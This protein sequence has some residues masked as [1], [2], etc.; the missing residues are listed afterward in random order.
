MAI[1][2]PTETRLSPHFLLSDFMGCNSVYSKGY[3][4]VF[5]KVGLDLRLDNAKALCDNVLEPILANAGP[6]TISYGFISPELSSKIVHYQDPHKP[7]HHRWDLGAAADI[8]VHNWV[9][10]F[11]QLAKLSHASPIE[12]A[13]T[14]MSD[15][16]LSRLITYS[17]SPYIC[18]AVSAV[19]IHRGEPRMAWYENRYAG[20]PR[21]K[22]D[23]R[24][25]GSD[26]LREEALHDIMQDGFEHDWRGAGYPTYHGGGTKQFQH[27][28]TGKYTM[29]S[30]WLFDEEFV[31]EGVPNEPML[32][33]ALVREAFD[34]AGHAYDLLIDNLGVP[35]LSIVSAYTSPLSLR[36]I[37]G[38]DWTGDQIVFEVVPPE[39]RPP[40]D[41]RVRALLW[42]AVSDIMNIEVDED[43]LIITVDREYAKNSKGF[44][45]YES[46]L[47]AAGARVPAVRRRPGSRP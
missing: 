35:R 11:A 46:R 1:L 20:K 42:P 38:R 16:P 43:R 30:D 15:M 21:C 24:K 33:N 23:Y 45:R 13:L 5:E 10:S 37:K 31:R 34:I 29:V 18:A 6:V 28:R 44:T 36:H 27:R 40:K 25:L 4:N 12:F 14:H 8:C 47:A 2:N 32:I 26:R 7:S 3:R 19:E 9:Q 17:E 41:A 39:Y 22:P